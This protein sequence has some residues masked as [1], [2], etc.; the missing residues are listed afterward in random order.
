MFNLILSIIILIFLA[1]FILFFFIDMMVSFYFG[2]PFVDTGNNLVD[3]IVRLGNPK[4]HDIFYDLGCGSGKIV[5]AFARKQV[6]RSTGIEITPS[7]YHLSKFRN[8]NL[9]NAKIIYKNFDNVD[10]SDGTIIYCYLF[11][12]LVQKLAKRFE[13][14][15]KA[16]TK[17][18]CQDFPIE[19]KKPEQIIKVGRH[20]LFLYKY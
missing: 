15:L 4:S 16:N 12:S 6:L 10:F 9:K 17:V 18:I 13:R 3:A 8:R 1:G 7:A 20:K 19:S 11:P 2:A 5:C 14:Q